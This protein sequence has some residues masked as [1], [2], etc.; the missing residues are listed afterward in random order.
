M[1]K[2]PSSAYSSSQKFKRTVRLLQ[3]SHFSL[4]KTYL[5]LKR[6]FLCPVTTHVSLIRSF[7]LSSCRK[8]PKCPNFWLPCALG[9]SPSVRLAQLCLVWVGHRPA[10][11]RVRQTDDFRAFAASCGVE[12]Q[13]QQRRQGFPGGCVRVHLHVECCIWSRCILIPDGNKQ[14][15][16]PLG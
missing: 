9:R 2:G 7:T 8:S 4:K 15:F 3:N 10:S 12:E 6:G 11:S 1:N 16:Q 13:P 14:V 5:V